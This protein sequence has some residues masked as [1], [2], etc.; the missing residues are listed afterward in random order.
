MERGES[1]SDELDESEIESLQKTLS[2]LRG[3]LLT[4]IG[5]LERIEKRLEQYESFR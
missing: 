1:P 3:S 2:Q 4:V 5:G